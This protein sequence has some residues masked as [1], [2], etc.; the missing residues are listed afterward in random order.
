M[1]CV[2]FM[3]AWC[4]SITSSPYQIDLILSS[5][6]DIFTY[7]KLFCKTVGLKVEGR[8]KYIFGHYVVGSLCLVDGVFIWF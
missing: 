8:Y 5:I 3:Y 4:N 1:W 7:S 6:K 2:H